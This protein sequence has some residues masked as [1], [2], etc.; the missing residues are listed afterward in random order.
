MSPGNLLEIIPADLLDTLQYIIQN[1]KP[2]FLPF[3]EISM[4]HRLSFPPRMD[5]PEVGSLA[6]SVYAQYR[7]TTISRIYQ[8]TRKA[9]S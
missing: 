2:S 8:Q 5:A 7:L 4:M 9:D 3:S 1:F 6:P